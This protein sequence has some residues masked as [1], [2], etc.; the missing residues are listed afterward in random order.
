VIRPTALQENKYRASMLCVVAVYFKISL[1][2]I[3]HTTD[4][5]A[6]FSWC[7]C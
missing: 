7:S 3:A 1:L 6:E 2:L 5:H 4:D